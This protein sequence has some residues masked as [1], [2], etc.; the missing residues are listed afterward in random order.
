MKLH[1]ARGDATLFVVS[2][3]ARPTY[4]SPTSNPRIRLLASAFDFSNS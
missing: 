1:Y 4:L 3:T 2:E